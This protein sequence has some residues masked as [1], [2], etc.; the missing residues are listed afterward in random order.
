MQEG[1]PS[2]AEAARWLREQRPVP[3]IDIG[4]RDEKPVA[5]ENRR[6]ILEILFSPSADTP[7]A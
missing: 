3:H 6:R 1:A 5:A 7:S 2:G 4:W